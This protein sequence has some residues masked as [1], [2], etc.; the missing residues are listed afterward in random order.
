MA[1]AL[2]T[3]ITGSGVG[4]PKNIVRNAAL[5]RIMDTSDE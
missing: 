5:A 3:I 2:R 1:P 4:V